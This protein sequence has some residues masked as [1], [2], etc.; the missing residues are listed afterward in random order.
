MQVFSD[1]QYSNNKYFP[2]RNIR[3]INICL[4]AILELQTF[5]QFEIFEQEIF[6]DLQIQTANI[7]PIRIRTANIFLFA[8]LKQFKQEMCADLQYSK[9]LNNKYF[10]NRKIRNI[11]AANISKFEIFEFENSTCS[12]K[13]ILTE[14]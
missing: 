8:I 1:P 13:Q 6:A 11:R 14:T 5:A 2:I 7:C 3:N 12:K 4:F 9:Y 10:L